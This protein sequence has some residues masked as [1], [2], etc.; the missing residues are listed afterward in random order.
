MLHLLKLRNLVSTNNELCYEDFLI[1]RSFGIS[2][3]VFLDNF[4][5]QNLF[6]GSFV[7]YAGTNNSC[8][9]T[10]SDEKHNI[11]ALDV[12]ELN[13]ILIHIRFKI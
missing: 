12:Q 3:Y 11:Y 6:S 10:Y 7:A 8:C 5:Y 1:D 4:W 9:T 2:A 13:K